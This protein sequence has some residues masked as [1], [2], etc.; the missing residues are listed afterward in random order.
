MA[1]VMGEW[2]RAGSPCGGGLVLWLR[3]LYRSAGW[4]LLDSTGRPKLALRSLARV[5]SPVAVWT[6]DEGLNGIAVHVAND[7]PEPLDARLRVALY[8]DLEVRVDSGDEELV[9]PPRSSCERGVEALLGHFADAALAYRFGPPSHHA[10]VASLERGGDLLG[11]AVRFPAGHPLEREP[12]ERLGLEVSA[13]PGEAGRVVVTLGCGRLVWG[14]R[15]Q[16]TGYEP[17]DDGFTLEPGC[18]RR[19]EMQATSG[20]HEPPAIRVTALNL[21]GIVRVGPAETR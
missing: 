16:A 4:G 1:E 3:D 9:L 21:D 20:D 10:V 19:I 18:E 13:G 12:A 17:R 11:Q 15:L 5:L 6:T 7:R 14:V 8:R 2:R